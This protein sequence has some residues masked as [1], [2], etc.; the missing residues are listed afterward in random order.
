MLGVLP[1]LMHS[2]LATVNCVI[3][4]IVQEN[5][6]LS[7]FPHSD[8]KDSEIQE[9]NAEFSAWGLNRVVLPMVETSKE[10]GFFQKHKDTQHH[11][12]STVSVLFL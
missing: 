7:L 1:I 6:C 4:S 8:C 12:L 9:C 5:V 11:Y 2:I 3:I 10:S